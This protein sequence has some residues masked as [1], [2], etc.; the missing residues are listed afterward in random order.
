MHH[1]TIY[2]TLNYIFQPLFKQKKLKITRCCARDILCKLAI[3]P[4]LRP[5]ALFNNL[6]L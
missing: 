3:K 5:E 6:R 4:T 2:F 1:D